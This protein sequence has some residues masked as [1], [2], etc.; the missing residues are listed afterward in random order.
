MFKYALFVPLIGD[1][2]L[3]NKIPF[4][5]QKQNILGLCSYKYFLMFGRWK[6]FLEYLRHLFLIHS[7]CSSKKTFRIEVKNRFLLGF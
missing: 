2:I 5:S 3:Y 7:A 1:C 6:K 4:I